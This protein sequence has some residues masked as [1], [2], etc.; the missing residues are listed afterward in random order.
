M[1]RTVALVGLAVALAH[2]PP[3]AL[4]QRGTS[5]SYGSVGFGPQIPTQSLTPRD[6]EW[7]HDHESENSAIA[8]AEWVR[9]HSGAGAHGFFPFQ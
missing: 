6:R 8:G 3:A 4:A 1:L 7:N 9:E 2:S 5:S